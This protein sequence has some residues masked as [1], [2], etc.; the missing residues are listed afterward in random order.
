MYSVHPVHAMSNGTLPNGIMDPAA[1]IDPS[2]LSPP[3][4]TGPLPIAHCLSSL[5]VAR[6]VAP[7]A[8]PTMRS[9]TLPPAGSARGLKRS[10]SPDNTYGDALSGD[11]DAGTRR[12]LPLRAPPPR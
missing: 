5:P 9:L 8:P 4:T 12:S 2:A 11:L 1:T 6:R 3:G 10:R 7:V